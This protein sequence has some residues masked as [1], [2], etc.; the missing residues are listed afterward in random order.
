[1][2]TNVVLAEQKYL[3]TAH[4]QYIHVLKHFMVA[5]I[6]VLCF[7]FMEEVRTFIKNSVVL[8]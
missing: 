4:N 5:D 7:S 8:V 6:L 3:S 2:I 1:M